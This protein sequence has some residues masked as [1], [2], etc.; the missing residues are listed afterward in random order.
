VSATPKVAAPQ[1]SATPK[2]AAPQVSATP[3]VAAPQVSATPK[4]AAPQVSATPKVA[5]PQ[6]SAAPKVAAP[7][8]SAAPKVAGVAAKPQQKTKA[9]AAILEGLNF[10]EAEMPPDALVG[11]KVGDYEI[12]ARIGTSPSGSIYR[13]KQTSM[14]RNVRFY[15]LDSAK[16]ADPSAIEAFLADASAKANV[17]HPSVFAIYEEGEGGGTFYFSCEY[18][19]CSSLE[20]IQQAGRRLNELQALHILK[21]VADVLG[22]L[23]RAGTPHEMISA[24]SILIGQHGRAR[25]ANIA[26]HQPA[27][28]F[29]STAEM[30]RLAALVLEAMEPVSENPLGVR[31]LLEQ[32]AAGAGPA[33]WPAFSQALRA[34]E[35]KVRP[36]DA[37]KLDAQERAAIRMVEEAKKRQ[38]RNMLVS[39]ALSLVLLTAALTAAYFFIFGP[40]GT[41]T[42]KYESMIQIPA[43][44]FIYQDGEKVTLPTFYIDEFEVTIAQYA[45]FLQYLEE[46]PGEAEKFAHPDQPKGKSHVPAE[47]ADMDELRPPMPGYY[48]R[49]R[50]WGRYQAAALSLDSPVFGV[51][52]FDA[53]AYAKWKGRRLPTEQEWEKA[54]RG[55]DGRKF[56]W[57]NEPDPKNVNSGVDLD[58]NPKK[59]GDIDGYKRWAPVDAIRGDRSPYGVAGMAGNVSEWTSSFDTD[60]QFSSGKLPVIRGGNWRN[61][62]YTIT[63]RVLLL[64]DLQADNGL[65]FRTASDS[66]PAQ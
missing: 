17:N 59:G 27:E 7:Q 37:Y 16:A 12:E 60:P 25:V 8:V 35:P 48:T 6:V 9:P 54:G 26:M 52:W 5:A 53:Y 40:K 2:V 28:I 41:D 55:T 61:P 57:G 32:T 13:A 36:Q 1:V 10:G 50:R 24:R 18:E 11:T 62:D 42:K 65:G 46:N 30:T 23:A 56:P 31:E 20:Q 63:R 3:K 4:V 43:G 33:S 58:P 47:W 38:R 19:P 14:N 21:V 34:L 64:T 51:D 45:K 66:P 49:A 44:E 29:D 39:S 22:T 15:T